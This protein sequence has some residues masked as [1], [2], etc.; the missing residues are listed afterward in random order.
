MSI[1]SIKAP[2]RRGRVTSPDGTDIA[3]YVIGSGPRT[4]LMPPAMG[5]PLIAMRPILE[6]FARDYTIVSWD[7]R[8]FYASGRPPS[9]SAMRV[10]DHLL[11]MEAVVAAEKLDRF[12]LGGWSMGVQLSLEYHHRHPHQVSALVLISGPYERALSAVL[13]FRGGEKLVKAG[14]RA[15]VAGSRVLNPLSRAILGAKGMGKVL[16]K[17]GVLAENPVEFEEVLG[18]FCQVDWGY[19]FSMTRQLHDH[20]AADYLGEIRVPTLVTT[21]TRDMVTPQETAEEMA[22][23]IPGAELFVVDRATH[24]ILTEFP[25]VVTERIAHFLA[26][27]G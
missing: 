13:G 20:S 5:A 17:V 25:E 12:V 24:Y 2:L 22:R 15:A 18:E 10:E 21:G 16:H 6:R 8:G 7:Q 9:R 26:K 3:Y 19:Y 1:D 23:R 27:V 11:D 14:L 4:W